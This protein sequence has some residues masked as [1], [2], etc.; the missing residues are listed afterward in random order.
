MASAYVI[1]RST[2]GG[3]GS[4]SFGAPV[5]LTV[6][7]S[8][9]AGVSTDATRADHK[10][11]LPAFGSGA[12]T[13]CEGND[14]RLSDSRT[15]TAHASTH[16]PGGTDALTTAAAGTISPDDTAAEGT[17]VSFSRS[18]HRHAITAGAPSTLAMGG[19]NTEGTASEFARKDHIHAI[20][21]PA[22]DTLASPTDITTLNASSSAHGLLPKLPG[23]ATK[24]LLGD[25]TYGSVA[26]AGS[27]GVWLPDAIPTSPHAKDREFDS[28]SEG[29]WASINTASTLTY[30]VANSFATLQC[31]ATGGNT[32]TGRYLAMPT[33][34]EWRIWAKV[35]MSGAPGTGVS[36]IGIFLAEDATTP[37]SKKFATVSYIFSTGTSN[38]ISADTWTNNAGTL[39]NLNARTKGAVSGYVG[40]GYDGT[41]FTYWASDNGV[42]WW[43][44]HS[45]AKP[46]TPLHHGF[47]VNNIT[48]GETLYGNFD[49][50]RVKAATGASGSGAG[51]FF[52]RRV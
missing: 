15:P 8:N 18:D 25:G 12:G 40:L 38:I 13:F 9:T 42:N 48:T 2:G 34:A 16:L 10:H 3:G 41:N 36:M 26:S 47:F 20:T 4:V 49:F 1:T 45:H 28:E 33:E 11:A 44:I 43:R 21:N 24:V 23:D 39:T 35:G 32:L 19:S 29:S 17:A 22:L 37:G 6:G 27:I 14:S 46:F 50:V 5:A 31:T 51:L 52:G 30:S 7:G